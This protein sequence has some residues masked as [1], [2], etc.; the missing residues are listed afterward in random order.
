MVDLRS[1]GDVAVERRASWDFR[2]FSAAFASA[3]PSRR[4]EAWA[5]SAA[6]SE[7]E[8]SEDGGAWMQW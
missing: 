3:I 2:A 4:V 7:G 8:S 6:R 1:S 5:S